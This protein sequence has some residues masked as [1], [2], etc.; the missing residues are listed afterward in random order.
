MMNISYIKWHKTTIA[1]G[2]EVMANTRCAICCMVRD[3]EKA[4]KKNLKVIEE[5]RAQFLESYLIIIENDSQDG[6]KELVK[7]LGQKENRTFIDSFDTGVVTLPKKMKS[8]VNPSYSEYRIQKM[9]DFRNRYLEILEGQ[10]GFKKIDWVIVID[11]DVNHISLSGIKHS[12][13]LENRW[14]VVHANGRQK[15]GWVSNI[16]YDVYALAEVGERS[17]VTEEGMRLRVSQMK[18][19]KKNSH[20]YTWL[21]GSARLLYTDLKHYAVSSI[22]VRQTMI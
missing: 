4:L 19:I 12:F 17:S 13:G 15:R 9:A 10:V 5:L 6:T 22:D 2:E 21:L 8:G 3:C 14:D 1:Q 18:H 11:P 7:E 16:Y 20:F